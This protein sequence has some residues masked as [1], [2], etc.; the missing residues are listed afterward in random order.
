M[1]K[2]LKNITFITM[3]T[4]LISSPFKNVKADILNDKNGSIET[5]NR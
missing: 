5:Y 2:F 1:N 3:S 4:I